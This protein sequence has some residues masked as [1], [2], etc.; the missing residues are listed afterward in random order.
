MNDDMPDVRTVLD[1][2]DRYDLRGRTSC[3]S[4]AVARIILQLE[5]DRAM[6]LAACEH[7]MDLVEAGEC[8]DGYAAG[9]VR[10]AVAAVKERRV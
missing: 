3:V 4:S 1:V 8:S 2:Y 6:L 9:L 10:T 5:N 7:I